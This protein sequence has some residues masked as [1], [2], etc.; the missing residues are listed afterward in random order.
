MAS[1]R[2]KFSVGL[3]V[4]IGVSLVI[5]FTLIL[6]L[7]DYFKEGQR[8]V[9]YFEDSVRGLNPSAKVRYRGVEVGLVEAINL[10]PDGNLVEV[11]MTV[12]KQL[13]D[14]S[15]VVATIRGVGITGIMYIDLDRATPKDMEETPALTFTPEY[16]VIATRPSEMSRMIDGVDKIIAN[17]QDLRIK[18]ISEGMETALE[19][20]NRIAVEARIGEVSAGI[21]ETLKKGNAILDT[22]KWEETHASLMETSKAFTELA[23]Q[24][25]RTMTRIDQMVEENREPLG[26]TLA[27][28]GE[29]V[30]NASAFFD[31]AAAM[32]ADTDMRIEAYDQK[33]GTISDDLQ[34]AI[35]NLNRLFEQVASN[36]SRLI[37]GRPV[38]PKPIEE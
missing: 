29:A 36:P 30:K 33:L 38:P 23:E 27:D 28:A 18:E 4:I 35:D 20:F 21:R 24:S 10:A 8:Y 31:R 14:V 5:F 7:S 11:V 13:A 32:T 37:F 16:P 12:D 26:K 25:R 22:A 19:N 9:G 15:D 34:Q 1:I 3:F 6:G 2:Q 17:L